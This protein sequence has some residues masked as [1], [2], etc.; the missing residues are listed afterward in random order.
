MFVTFPSADVDYVLQTDLRAL[1]WALRF[2][3]VFRLRHSYCFVIS[4]D[5]LTLNQL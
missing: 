4:F 5:Y 2:Y 3:S 1:E